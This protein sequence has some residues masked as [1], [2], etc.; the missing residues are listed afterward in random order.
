[1]SSV[2]R[3][4]R[5]SGRGFVM[6]VFVMVVFV[7]V[8]FAVLG[9]REP[10]PPRAVS[11]ERDG[12]SSPSTRAADDMPAKFSRELERMVDRC[13]EGETCPPPGSKARRVCTDVEAIPVHGERLQALGSDR[14]GQPEQFAAAV[15]SFVRA[16]EEHEKA[17]R[18]GGVPQTDAFADSAATAHQALRAA[19]DP[20]AA[21]AA[22]MQH[23][24][25]LGRLRRWCAVGEVEPPKPD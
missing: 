3:L 20:D 1:M 12:A 16:F 4:R 22:I 7:M 14:S 17:A 15:Q 6:V 8:V 11:V 25:Q 21:R 10:P 9:C 24:E 19:K 13:K 18:P 2:V 23:L 5:R